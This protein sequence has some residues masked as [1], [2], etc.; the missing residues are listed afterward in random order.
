MEIDLDHF[1]RDFRGDGH[2]L[3]RSEIAD[4]LDA[5]IPTCGFHPGI[6]DRGRRRP[7]RHGASAGSILVLFD[8]DYTSDNEADHQEGQ[9]DSQQHSE[10]TSESK[11][12][13]SHR[14]G[15]DN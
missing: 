13:V 1:A 11:R 15:N 10:G 14:L 2:V 6:R 8:R 7:T 12:L 4:S 3:N 5:P 9:K